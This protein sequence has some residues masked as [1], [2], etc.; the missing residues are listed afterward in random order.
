MLLL[1]NQITGRHIVRLNKLT[2][3]SKKKEGALVYMRSETLELTKNIG[4]GGLCC[5][6]YGT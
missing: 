1:L 6:G 3:P 2:L 5:G 4:K